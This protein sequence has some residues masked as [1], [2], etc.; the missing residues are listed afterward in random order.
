MTDLPRAG[1]ALFGALCLALGAAAPLGAQL[2]F[3]TAPV[4]T[5]RIELRG[6]F[7]PATHEFADGQRR[8]LAAPI[9][10]DV[11]DAGHSPLVSDMARRLSGLIAR[12]AES[13]SLG[14]LDAEVE[15]QRG[16][17]VI[18]LAVGV[19]PR[20]TIGID[21]PI[22]S[23]RTQA[24]LTPHSDA[25]TLGLNPA[26]FGGSSSDSYFQQFTA[27]LNELDLRL[28][29]GAFDDDPA[30]KAA[31][32]DLV[33]T[34]PAFRDQLAAFL[35]DPA[36]ATPVLPLATSADGEA[37]R[38][39]T[40]DVRDQF[41]EQFGVT[42]FTA[43]IALPAAP[44][45]DADLNGL[46]ASPSGFGLLPT[47][48]PPLVGLGDARV[49]ATAALF[50][51]GTARDRSQLSL[52]GQAGVRL[53][54]GTAPRPEYLRDQ[55]TGNHGYAIDVGGVIDARWGG[56]G[57]RGSASFTRRFAAEQTSR[58][59]LTDEY[60]LPASRTTLLRRTPGHT[61]RLDA[62]PYLRIAD[63]L[64]LA[65]RIAVERTGD[66][67]WET[68]LGSTAI[69]GGDV[70]AMGVGSG[71]TAVLAGLGL[72]YAHDGVNKEGVVKM[73]V[74]AGLGLQRVVTASGGAVA[75]RL[76]TTIWFRVYKRLF[77]R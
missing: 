45:A 56:V 59:G 43:A 33:A 68:S 9:R 16:R 24:R 6:A 4:G 39:R 20:V 41:G 21:L 65:G 1:H 55:G 31:A 17:G 52:W 12:P 10:A 30:L 8:D 32:Q 72:S 7:D 75:D 50:T 18:G 44:V 64:A 51:H 2:P 49:G 47:T 71:S 25:A 40:N 62:Q 67:R 22:V 73:P 14:A 60:L 35:I 19:T 57:V 46:L 77:S 27:A 28:T 54:T 74:E 58:V 48:D 11:L 3:M 37:L 23:S 34:G 26:L 38:Q 63:H 42:G 70:G 69:S 36:T 29:S 66:D 61:L 53:P 76:T 5:L 15:F 13:A